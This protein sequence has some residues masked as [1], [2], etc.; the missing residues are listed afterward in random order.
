[1]AN[2][3]RLKQVDQQEFSGYVVQVT[4]DSFYP[5]TN[6]SGYISSVAGDPSFLVLSGNLSST[7]SYLASLNSA[8]SGALNTSIVSTGNAL[9]NRI[10]S[11]SGNLLVTNS[12]LSYVSGLANA[13]NSGVTALDT[14]FSGVLSGEVTDLESQI[15]GVSGV[16]NT[17]ISTVSGNLSSRIGS[18]ESSFAATGG[19][20]VDISSNSQIISGTKEFRDRVAFAQINLKPYS[21]NYSNP[22]G[23]NQLVFTQV[24]QGYSVFASGYGTIT[25]DLFV[26]KIMQQNN[27]EVILASVIYTGSY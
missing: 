17:K 6:P 10:S 12:N 13:A 21:G 7:G 3:I 19:N 1:M 5:A 11:L 26:T 15:S 20:F 16:L 25:G 27:I 9:N 23:Q 18:L 22:G 8:T 2:L 14:K 24:T 4:D